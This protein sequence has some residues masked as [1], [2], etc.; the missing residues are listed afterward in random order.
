MLPILFFLML[1]ML[2]GNGSVQKEPAPDQQIAQGGYSERALEDYAA[3]QYD[4]AFGGSSAYEDNLLL[5]FLVYDDR[6]DF[7]YM[8][9]V[10]DHINDT[11]YGLLGGNDTVLGRTLERYVQYGYESTLSDDLSRALGALAGEIAGASPKGAFLCTEAHLAPSEPL[12]NDSS[13]SLDEELLRSALR[14]FT[15]TTGI[16]IA[17]AIAD[18]ED[19]FG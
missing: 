12:I 15:E 10:G 13:L 8:T 19:I 18:A 14:E 1:A 4:E 2:F 11:T 17:L 9:W 5:T 7:T 6:S 16:P 3:E